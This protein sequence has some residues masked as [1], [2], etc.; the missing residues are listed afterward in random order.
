MNSFAKA[1]PLL[2]LSALQ[3][4][5]CMAPRVAMA[6]ASQERHAEAPAPRAFSVHDTDRDGL[7]S[8]DEYRK[9]IEHV[10]TQYQSMER[11]MRRVWPPLKFEV[12][13]A[14]GDGFITESELVYA[15]NR[16]LEQRRRERWRGRWERAGGDGRGGNR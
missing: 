2:L 10:A 11:P 15:L 8:R 16:R 13:D 1:S 9:F 4:S 14:N 7:L 12:I 5:F 6:E 3:V